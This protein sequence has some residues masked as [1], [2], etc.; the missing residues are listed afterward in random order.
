MRVPP[1]A[2]FLPLVF[3]HGFRPE[4]SYATP[5]G[6]G[7]RFTIEALGRLTA[8]HNRVVNMLVLPARTKADDFLFTATR[9]LLGRGATGLTALN[10]FTCA[11][12]K[13]L[14]WSR[15]SLPARALPARSFWK[16]TCIRT[17]IPQQGS[18]RLLGHWAPHVAAIPTCL[19]G[20]KQDLD[21]RNANA[22]CPAQRI[23]ER[24]RFRPWA[25]YQSEHPGLSITGQACAFFCHN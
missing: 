18:T 7:T 5:G 3:A 2:A 17:S 13:Y 12:H 19:P 24:I 23:Y 15:L 1:P 10:G 9:P 8:F 6:P 22:R 14:M 16:S 20:G 11:T 25:Y 21:S 4:G